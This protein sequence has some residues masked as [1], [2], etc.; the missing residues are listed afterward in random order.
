MFTAT[1]RYMTKSNVLLKRVLSSVENIMELER[2]VYD[3]LSIL[4]SINI[5]IL[6][7]GYSL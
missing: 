1:I 7:Y 6:C 3:L 2:V 4:L 5:I